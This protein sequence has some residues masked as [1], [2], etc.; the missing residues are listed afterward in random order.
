MDGHSHTGPVLGMGLFAGQSRR[1]GVVS[2]VMYDAELPRQCQGCS[3]LQD[4]TNGGG[5]GGRSGH[6]FYAFNFHHF[7]RWQFDVFRLLLWLGANGEK[8]QLRAILPL[9]CDRI[10]G[11][12]C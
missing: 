4:K 2:L 6:G 9:P 1:V 5:T 8:L 10:L 7:S 12:L 11:S 3:V